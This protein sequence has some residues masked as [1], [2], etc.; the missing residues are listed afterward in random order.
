MGY[1]QHHAIVITDWSKKGI[2]KAYEKANEVFSAAWDREV[3]VRGGEIPCISPIIEGAA[4]SQYTFMIAPDGSKEGWGTSDNYDL[5][6]KEFLDW[7]N[8]SDLYCDYVEITF[9]GDYNRAKVVRHKD[10]DL[11]EEY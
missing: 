9:G 2:D 8:S 1:I 5:A 11:E 7:L 10:G 3:F 6:R 4:N